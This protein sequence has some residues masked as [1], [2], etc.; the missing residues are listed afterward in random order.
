MAAQGEEDALPSDIQ[1][2]KRQAMTAFGSNNI[3][4]AQ[5]FY[6]H[7]VS[8]SILL[9]LTPVPLPAVDDSTELWHGLFLQD[10]FHLKKLLSVCFFKSS[11]YRRSEAYFILRSFSVCASSLV[12]SIEG[13]RHTCLSMIWKLH[14]RQRNQKL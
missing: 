14:V 13:V 6:T 3:Y 9:L 12:A 7:H 11:Q 8:P 4:A 2:L 10:L 1:M 5:D